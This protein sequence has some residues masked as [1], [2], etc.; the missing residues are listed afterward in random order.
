MASSLLGEGARS[1]FHVLEAEVQ[2]EPS[3]MHV[4]DSLIRDQDEFC[5]KSPRR[6]NFCYL[7]RKIDTDTFIGIL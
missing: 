4:G 6:R 2:D 3:I 7:G 5:R 1:R